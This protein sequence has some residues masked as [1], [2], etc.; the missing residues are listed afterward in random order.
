MGENTNGN[1]GELTPT[2]RF[3]LA[4]TIVFFIL[5]VIYLLRLLNIL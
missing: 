4:M 5:A 3:R 2:F 1:K